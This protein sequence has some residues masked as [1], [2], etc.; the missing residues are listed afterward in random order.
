MNK[1]KKNLESLRR[2][3]GR[4]VAGLKLLDAVARDINELRKRAAELQDS[5]TSALVCANR[6]K[7]NTIHAEKELSKIKA[8]LEKEKG[9]RVS[10]EIHAKRLAGRVTTLEL[11]AEGKDEGPPGGNSHRDPEAFE[12]IRLLK[13]VRKRHKIAPR[14][15][16]RAGEYYLEDIIKNFSDDELLGLGLFVAGY[17]VSGMPIT[18][19]SKNKMVDADG[20]ELRNT[21]KYL[22]WFRLLIDPES[23]EM[24]LAKLVSAA[25]K[26]HIGCDE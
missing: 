7:E 25:D 22:Q 1:H 24:K 18:V 20:W 2:H 4:D 14:P 9:R 6:H 23:T 10:T 15:A 5:E 13:A 11:D 8:E 17:S 21:I 12:I 26:K 19:R 16:L 3:L